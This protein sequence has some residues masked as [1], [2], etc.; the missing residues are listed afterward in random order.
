MPAKYRRSPSWRRPGNGSMGRSH[1]RV[2]SAAVGRPAPA[3][4]ATRVARLLGADFAYIASAFI[5]TL[6]A[7]AAEGYKQMITTSTA[8]DIVYSNLFTGVHGN[9]RKPSIVA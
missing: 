4:R 7:N 6:E 8:E 9:Y 2:R 1:C 5:A 3:G